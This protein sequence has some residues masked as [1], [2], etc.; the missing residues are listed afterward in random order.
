MAGKIRIIERVKITIKPFVFNPKTTVTSDN[1]QDVLAKIKA[2]Y[3]QAA[4]GCDMV[5][6]GIQ[7]I[8]A[9]IGPLDID[10]SKMR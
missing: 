3:P 6:Q 8:E 9:A 4:I 5:D 10:L 1:V 7:L 2:Y